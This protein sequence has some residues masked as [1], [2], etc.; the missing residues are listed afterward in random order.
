MEFFR[1]FYLNNKEKL[2]GYLVRKSGDPALA[3]DLVQESFTR[4]LEQYRSRE[5]SLALLFTI[6]RNLFYDHMRRD[7]RNVEMVE[8]FASVQEDEE[9][10]YM[11]REDS[12]RMLKTLQLLDDEDRDILALVVSG[13]M[14][15]REIAA[16]RGCNETTIKVRV[17]RARQKLR[18]LLAK[19]QS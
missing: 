9:Q 7:R 16:I 4:Y 12:Q 11:Q 15:Y 3:S 2:Y 10:A 5:L 19:E 8:P 17:H 14:P 13:G 1:Q 18:Q 6:G